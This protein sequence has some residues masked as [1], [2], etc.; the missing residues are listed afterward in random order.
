MKMLQ[1]ILS[2]LL[3]LVIFTT[4]MYPCADKFVD[5][6]E[7]LSSFDKVDLPTYNQDRDYHSLD[8]CSPLCA[9]SCCASSITLALALNITQV[10]TVIH[11]PQHFNHYDNLFSRLDSSIW[12]PPKIA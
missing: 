12:Q 1:Q 6:T 5:K 7:Q 4:S 2:I 3:V 9:C 10:K 11:S 8:A